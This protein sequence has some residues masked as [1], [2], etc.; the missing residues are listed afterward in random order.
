MSLIQLIF[1][2]IGISMESMFRTETKIDFEN[3][4]FQVINNAVLGKTIEK[5]K[6]TQIY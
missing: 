5:C 6:K 3:D 4:F 1:I 2:C